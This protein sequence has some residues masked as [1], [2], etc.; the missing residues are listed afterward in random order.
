VEL[1]IIGAEDEL[2]VTL[3]TGKVTIVVGHSM[4]SFLSPGLRSGHRVEAVDAQNFNLVYNMKGPDGSG[5]PRHR[6]YNP[7]RI[8]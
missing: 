4:T 1:L 7:S 5:P 3:H 2:R 8:W 6:R